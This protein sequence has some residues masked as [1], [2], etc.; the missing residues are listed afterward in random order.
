MATIG[1]LLMSVGVGL[2]LARRAVSARLAAL[3]S[4]TR[5]ENPAADRSRVSAVAPFLDEAQGERLVTAFGLVS[6]SFGL[7]SF[8]TLLLSFLSLRAA[9]S[10]GAQ[11]SFLGTLTTPESQASFS[12]AAEVA[13]R[14][15]RETQGF[16]VRSV[17]FSARTELPACDPG[18]PRCTQ[19]AAPDPTAWMGTLSWEE[20]SSTSDWTRRRCDATAL[21]RAGSTWTLE[22]PRT[23]PYLPNSF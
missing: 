1:T 22:I 10:P 11:Q 16:E 6:L 4:S 23:C 15:G 17:T 5:S 8:L 12:R 7:L 18:V 13:V 9:T 14:R 20:R 3:V 19:G 2:I 21:R